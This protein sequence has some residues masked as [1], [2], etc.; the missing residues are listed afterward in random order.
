MIC[1]ISVLGVLRDR[2]RQGHAVHGTERGPTSDYS[3][4][5]PWNE[6]QRPPC[7][8]TKTDP[9]KFTACCSQ[10][11]QGRKATEG[12]DQEDTV[13]PHQPA[14]PRPRTLDRVRDGSNVPSWERVYLSVAVLGSVPAGVPPMFAG[15]LPVG[16]LVELSCQRPE[17][18]T[19]VRLLA[20]RVSGPLL[21]VPM[22][23]VRSPPSQRYLETKGG[24]GRTA[25]KE[26]ERTRMPV[27]TCKQQAP[28]P[29]K[30]AEAQRCRLPCDH[31]H[32]PAHSTVKSES[33]LLG[34]QRLHLP[35]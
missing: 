34:R 10:V 31:G 26:W 11:C 23:S 3:L 8:R 4:N 1:N 21:P 6:V 12:G 25:D 20:C 15:T 17:G 28:K 29:R 32:A 16:S 35:S 18:L 24:F 2:E 19:L 22:A 14:M 33:R 7:F 9:M 13:A 30:R 5:L 27:L